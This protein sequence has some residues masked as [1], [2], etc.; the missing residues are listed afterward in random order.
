MTM[1]RYQ[2]TQVTLL[3]I[4]YMLVNWI[5]VGMALPCV[6]APPPSDVC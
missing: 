1:Q 5:V 3:G 4:V 2:A 6:F